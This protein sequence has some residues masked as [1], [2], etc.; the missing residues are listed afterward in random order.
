M[1]LTPPIPTSPAAS[2]RPLRT[3][4]VTCQRRGG[5]QP[6][7]QQQVLALG[8]HDAAL[9]APQQPGADAQQRQQHAGVH[10]DGPDLAHQALERVQ[11]PVAEEHLWQRGR[12]GCVCG[13][14]LEGAAGA[15]QGLGQGCGWRVMTEGQTGLWWVT[16]GGAVVKTAEPAHVVRSRRSELPLPRSPSSTWA[17]HTSTH[18]WNLPGPS[19]TACRTTDPHL[20]L[21]VRQRAS[22]PHTM[23]S[24]HPSA[25][26]PDP[27]GTAC[28]PARA[29]R[30]SAARWAA[31]PPHPCAQWR[32]GLSGTASAAPPWP[33]ATGWW[34]CRPPGR[35]PKAR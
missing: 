7:S 10:S 26:P 31:A 11:A 2:T 25:V 3:C 5:L 33:P 6:L 9:E 8:N 23:T 15:G 12:S 34:R 17:G 27:P 24:T 16:C 20:V 4:R 14:V 13:G 28:P 29:P 22:T 30:P 18:T 32:R 35:R 21:L 1:T 19:T